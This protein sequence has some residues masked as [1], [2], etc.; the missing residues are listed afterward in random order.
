MAIWSARHILY[1]PECI[2]IPI[3]SKDAIVIR[4]KRLQKIIESKSKCSITWV[5]ARGELI[6]SSSAI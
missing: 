5:L 3:V 4:M 1:S 6:V 2:E